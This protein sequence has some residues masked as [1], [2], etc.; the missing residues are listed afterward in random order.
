[1]CPFLLNLTSDS[2]VLIH[3]YYKKGFVQEHNNL[4]ITLT[5]TQENNNCFDYEK[6]KNSKIVF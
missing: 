3:L 2:M 4:L 1:M 5:K 6:V